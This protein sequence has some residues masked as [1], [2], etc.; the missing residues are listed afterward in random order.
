M[1]DSFCIS[2]IFAKKAFFFH[3][4]M[5]KISNKI[6]WFQ[7]PFR[8][9][10]FLFNFV[11]FF[12]ISFPSCLV[13]L[14]KFSVPYCCFL[15]D[16]VQS[17][18]KNYIVF[19]V[20]STPVKSVEVLGNLTI[21]SRLNFFVETWRRFNYKA[22]TWIESVAKFQCPLLSLTTSSYPYA[23]WIQGFET[24]IGM[25]FVLVIST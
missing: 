21:W 5:E 1:I 10:Y 22:D 13:F 9:I 6:F 7:L 4:Y 25:F 12:S 19:F 8:N 24:N 17:F 14:T 18:Q 23:N 11:R 15:W 16:H 3:Q 20:V 2:D